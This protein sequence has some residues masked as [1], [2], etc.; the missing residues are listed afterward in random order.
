AMLA[1][2]IVAGSMM[3]ARSLQKLQHQDFGY[4]VERRVVVGLQRL[5][6]TY[7]PRQLSRLYDD[8]ERRLARLRGVEGYGL[9]L[10]NPLTSVWR[11]RVVVAGHAA[12]TDD[13]T[14]WDRV[15]AGYLQQLGVGLVRGRW[16]TAADSD[17]GARVA[18]VNE[19]FV[20]RFFDRGDD[21]I[22]Q[23]FGIARPENAGT[24]RIVGVIHDAKFVRSG[25]RTP[26][27]PMFVLPLAQHVEY[28]ADHER[29]VET[30][31]HFI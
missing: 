27:A 26:A 30:L 18:I 24:F 10:Y 20:K 7:G 13:G 9:A 14:V 1:V 8:V 6:A 25:L 15:S 3:L 29:M 22:D 11:D 12:D 31:S 4:P 5:P 19:A 28:T 21:P 16:F 23:H 2:V 17:T